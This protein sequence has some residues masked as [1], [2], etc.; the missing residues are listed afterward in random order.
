MAGL[1][2]K[3]HEGVRKHLAKEKEKK[4][5]RKDTA[6]EHGFKS[7]EKGDVDHFRVHPQHDGSIHIETHFKEPAQSMRGP[8]ILNMEPHHHVVKS[9]K[10]AGKHMAEMMGEKEPDEAD[11][12]RVA[13]SEKTNER[14]V[15]KLE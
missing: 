7:R 1:G 12:A 2:E 10:H 4:G 13:G 11:T 8:S 3:I 5:E 9:M 6:T 14:S 15:N